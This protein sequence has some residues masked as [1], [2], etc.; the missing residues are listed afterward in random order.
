[1]PIDGIGSI[2][3]YDVAAVTD[4]GMSAGRERLRQDT[5]PTG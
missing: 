3:G 5:Q 1:M 4:A 2:P